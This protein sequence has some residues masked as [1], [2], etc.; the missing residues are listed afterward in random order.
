LTENPKEPTL[1]EPRP[2]VFDFLLTRRSRPAKTLTTPVPADDRL[3]L[4]LTAAARSPDHGALVPWRFVVLRDAALNRLADAVAAR[5]VERDLE[6]ELVAKARAVFDKSA[7]CVAVVAHPAATQKV[8]EVE[9]ILSAGAVC[10][11]L[12]NAAL[13]DG[14]GANWVTGWM[15]FDEVFL[16]RDLGLKS[17]EF[18]A[19]FVHIGTETVAPPDRPRPDIEAITD[20][21]DQ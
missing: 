1:P 2:E 10:L 14:W 21:V 19:G 18:V 20:W 15:A 11:S 7:L 12:L 9:Q 8:P 6:P 5:A 4:L 13:A 16:T 3:K 17:G